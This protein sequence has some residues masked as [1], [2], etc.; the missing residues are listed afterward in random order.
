[1]GTSNSLSDVFL[2]I[3]RQLERVVARVVPPTDIEDIVQETFVR[4]FEAEL[5]RE[6]RQPKAFMLKTALNL[7]LNHV[8]RSEYRLVNF[9]EDM[10]NWEAI[11]QSA[12]IEIGLDSQQRFLTF[13]KAVRQLPLQCRRAFILKKVYGLT[14]KETAEYLGIS[15]RTVE[16]HVARGLL[17]CWNYLDAR[18]MTVRPR[19]RRTPRTQRAVEDNG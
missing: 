10:P 8:S 15:E 19:L 1:M 17:D 4:S 5:Q 16:K 18:G 6:I 9:G 11:D 14:Q 3:R 12:S 7:A 2:T 13:C